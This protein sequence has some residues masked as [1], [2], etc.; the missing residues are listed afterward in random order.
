MVAAG[1]AA[2]SGGGC[3]RGGRGASPALS[4]PAACP[5]PSCEITTREYC[6]FMHGYFH[7][8]ATLCSQ[9]SRAGDVGHDASNNILGC[10]WDGCEQRECK[11][12]GLAQLSA[13]LRL[14]LHARL[15]WW[16]A[17]GNIGLEP[18]SPRQHRCPWERCILGRK[19]ALQH[20]WGTGDAQLLLPQ[21]LDAPHH[22]G[23]SPTTDAWHRQP[24]IPVTHPLLPAA[25]GCG[26][27]PHHPP[28]PACLCRCTAWT[29]S[30]ASCPSSTQR[31][32]TSSTACGCPCSCT[33]GELQ[34]PCTP[35][36]GWG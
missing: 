5:L 15:C 9:V 16:G 24:H 6:E 3:L 35:R 19:T 13:G 1:P 14:P 36:G 29:R 25:L 8:E 28:N 4:E 21:H 17:R 33:P 7:E 11:V 20:L 26:P 18:T 31:S 23:S 2:G 34:P 22:P 32:P 30:A 10:G 12:Q 27:S